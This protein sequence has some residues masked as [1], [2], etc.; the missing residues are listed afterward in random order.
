MAQDTLPPWRSPK[1]V[2]VSGVPDRQLSKSIRKSFFQSTSPIDRSRQFQDW[3]EDMRGEGYWE[4]SFVDSTRQGDSVHVHFRSGPRYVLD[5]LEL[6]G[7]SE[8][9]L[10]RI[11]QDKLTRKKGGLDWTDLENRLNFVVSDQ[12][13]R[14]YPFAQFSGLQLDF[15]ARNADTTGVSVRFPFS[16][17]SLVTIDSIRF[18]GSHRERESF[19]YNLMNI[20]PGDVFDQSTIDA[21]PRALNNSIYFQNAQPATVYFTPWETAIIDVKLEPRKAG[22]FDLL[23]GLLPPSTDSANFEFTGTLDLML[24]SPFRFGEIL[25]IKYDKLTSSSLQADIRV[26]VPYLLRTP[27][28]LGGEFHLLKQEED[29]LNVD[30]SGE[31]IYQ[32]T[33]DLLARFAT[34]VSTS[35]LLPDASNDT[36]NLQPEQLDANRLTFWGGVAFD[37]LDYRWNPT[38][39]LRIRLDGGI[40]SKTI[41]VN[42]NLNPE[43]YADINLDQPTQEVMF[44]FDGFIPLGNRHVLHGANRSYVLNM[45]DYFRTDQLQVG[46]ARSIRGFNENEFFTDLMLFFSGEYR[47]LLER[48]SYLVG[49]IDYAYLRDRV[50]DDIIRPLGVGIGMNYGTKAGIVSI[51]YAVGQTA[52]IPFNPARGKIHI[53]FLNQF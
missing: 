4:F 29:F 14:G 1:V 26:L 10:K 27:L 40:G 7:L 33:P 19:I 51:S 38:R 45:E 25:E 47:F 24:V 53:G 18:Q 21:I 39:G 30:F 5:R 41:F 11:E 36:T 52:D 23:V 32:F 13:D 6:P 15:D 9:Y 37:N 50:A 12:Q 44:E 22:K 2:E 35:R 20:Q 16:S 42:P 17:G 8:A 49:F 28:K 43:I 48:D 3:A 31:V 34:T 46:G